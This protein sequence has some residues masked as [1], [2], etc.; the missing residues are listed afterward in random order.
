MSMT[1]DEQDAVLRL[2]QS[3]DRADLQDVLRF[4]IIRNAA[5]LTARKPITAAEWDRLTPWQKRVIAWQFR[6]YLSRSRARGFI[7]TLTGKAG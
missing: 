4:V 6:F 2:L 5:R 1:K 7:R 3:L